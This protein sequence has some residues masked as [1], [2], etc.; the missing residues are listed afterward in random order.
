MNVHVSVCIVV[1]SVSCRYLCSVLLSVSHSL[2]VSFLCLVW[3]CGS[4]YIVYICLLHLPM[5]LCSLPLFPLPSASLY[6]PPSS[7]LLRPPPT[8]P[9]IELLS[10]HSVHIAL[11]PRTNHC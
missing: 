8:A 4:A 3:L 10:T 5:S 9:V 11:H 1:V 6:A 2:M 7:A